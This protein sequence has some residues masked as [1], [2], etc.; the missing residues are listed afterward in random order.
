MFKFTASLAVLILASSIHA[1]SFLKADDLN[2][3]GLRLYEAGDYDAAIK[4]F[5]EAIE[6]TSRLTKPKSLKNNIFPPEKAEERTAALR[7][8]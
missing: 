5:N 8:D 3:R 1:Q 4:A 2:D 6:L 7:G